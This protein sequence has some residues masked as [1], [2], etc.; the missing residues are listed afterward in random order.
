M[1]TIG[2]EVYPCCCW[3]GNSKDGSNKRKV[4]KLLK[5]QE[6]TF[7]GVFPFRGTRH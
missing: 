5:Q 1:D 2:Q 3:K 4:K 6:T 7:T